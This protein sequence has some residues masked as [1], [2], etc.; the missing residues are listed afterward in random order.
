VGQRLSEHCIGDGG[1]E[2]IPV[3]SCTHQWRP[4]SGI[5]DIDWTVGSEFFDK[6]GVPLVEPEGQRAQFT[7]LHTHSQ[8]QHSCAQ[9]RTQTGTLTRNTLCSYSLDLLLRK[10]HW[11]SCVFC[12]LAVRS[13]TDAHSKVVLPAPLSGLERWSVYECL[14]MRM[15]RRSIL[16]H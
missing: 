4:C 15:C 12:R 1:K 11:C 5:V 6:L 9:L 10:W 13:D 3:T 8:H 16:T 14:C 2:S 7:L